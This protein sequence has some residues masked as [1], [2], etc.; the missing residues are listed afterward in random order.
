MLKKIPNGSKESLLK[1]FRR[2]MSRWQLEPYNENYKPFKPSD[3]KQQP[4]Q[5]RL[6]KFSFFTGLSIG[7]AI[8]YF[9]G[10]RTKEEVSHLQPSN[11]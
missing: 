9:Y 10:K 2:P 5:A 6:S 11:K 3:F 1:F 4:E 8:M 7:G